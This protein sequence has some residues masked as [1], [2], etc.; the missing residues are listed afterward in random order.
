MGT[1]GL[2]PW[3]P[4]QYSLKKIPQTLYVHRCFKKKNEAPWLRRERLQNLLCKAKA[5][6]CTCT[7]L[8]KKKYVKESGQKQNQVVKNMLRCVVI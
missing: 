5:E 8:N 7:M 1:T 2:L 4:T 6:I 3:S